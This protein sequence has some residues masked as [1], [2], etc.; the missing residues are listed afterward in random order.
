MKMRELAQG[1]SPSH[2]LH[3][4][5]QRMPNGQITNAVGKKCV[6]TVGDSVALAACDG[7]GAWE[8]QGNGVLVLPLALRS[9][10]CSVA[11]AIS[12]VS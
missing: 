2:G 12:Q 8:T 6:G 3:L 7:G 10:C 9:L 1:A 11:V 5:R 4:P